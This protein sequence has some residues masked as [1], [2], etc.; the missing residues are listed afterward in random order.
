MLQRGAPKMVVSDYSTE[1]N[2]NAVPNWAD[3][4]KVE[5]HYIAPG[6]PM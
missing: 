5:W 3:E 4:A 2:S 1:F 6:K